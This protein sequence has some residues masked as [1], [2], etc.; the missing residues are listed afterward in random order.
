MTEHMAR[1]QR[2]RCHCAVHRN[3]RLFGSP[4]AGVDRSG[5]E[6]FAGTTRAHDE[7]ARLMSSHQF[8]RPPHLV[9]PGR[10]ADDPLDGRI[11]AAF[12]LDGIRDRIH[13]AGSLFCGSLLF[14]PKIIQARIH[15]KIEDRILETEF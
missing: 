4:A 6:F 8:N 5:D 15:A 1:K 9:G 13:E 3:K 11:D 10:D 14:K 2:A 12:P 7:H